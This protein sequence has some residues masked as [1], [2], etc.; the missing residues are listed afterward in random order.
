M[1]DLQFAFHSS[2]WATLLNRTSFETQ[3][4]EEKCAALGAAS[5]QRQLAVQLGR[6]PTPVHWR[7][8]LTARDA[9]AGGELPPA[10]QRV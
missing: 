4:A 2:G 5:S 8:A 6:L 3:S 10:P 1:T 7:E 9:A